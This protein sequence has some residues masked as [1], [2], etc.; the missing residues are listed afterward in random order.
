MNALTGLVAAVALA[1]AP[2]ARAAAQDSFPARPPAPGP[3]SPLTFPAFGDTTL[4]NGVNLVVIE[5]R[6]QPTVSM[7]LTFRGG[8]SFDPAG[9]EGLAELVA[10]LVTKGTPTRGAEQIAAT[11]EGAGGQLSASSDADFLTIS[12][13]VLSDKLDLAV[14]LLAD[15][16]RNATFPVDE[17]ELARTRYLSN[18]QAQLA[19]PD[20]IAARAFAKEIYGTHPYGRRPTE[21]S[22]KAITREDVRQFARTRLQPAGA[23]FVIAGDVSLAQV[24]ALFAKHFARWTGTAAVATPF[25]ALP[26]KRTPD[27]LLVHRPGSVQS[28]IIVGNPTMTPRDTNYYAARL[29]AHVLGGGTDSRLFLILREQKGWTYGA[30]AGLRRLRGMGYWEGTAEV[31]TAVTDSALKELLAQIHRIRTEVMPDSELTNAKGFLVGSFPRQIETPE[32]IASQVASVKR[33]GLPASYLETYRERLSAISPRRAQAAAANYFRRAGL[34]VVV[35]GDA[36]QVYDRLKAIAPVRLV[37]V[38]GAPLAIE[39]LSA[40]TGPVALDRTQLVTRSDSFRVVVQGNPMGIQVGTLH[41]DSGVQ[42]EATNIGGFLKQDTRVVFDTTD[43][44]VKEVHQTGSV[45]GQQLQTDLV[46][47][48]GRVKGTAM[49]PQPTGPKTITVDTTVVAGTID[50]NALS[51]LLPALPLE[52]GKTLALNVFVSSQ[53]AVIPAS[54]KVSGPESVT[55]PAGTFDALRV[56]VTGLPQGIAMWVSIAAPRRVVKIAPVGTPVVIELVK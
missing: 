53:A 40:P 1:A 8:A 15:V 12:S 51:V 37:A 35:V 3:L 56:D 20:V 55:V 5:N 50:E 52:A 16:T 17:L 10:E 38:E 22:Y 6:E 18:L 31:R 33:L 14:Q 26:V 49:T 19:Q 4:A 21:A 44:S 41:A 29:A 39:D 25:P 54:L 27:I 28:N 48:G 47:A 42:V 13:N 43:W 45:Q 34:T 30:F 24:R 2:A 11:I 32:Q 7:S 46:Y 36:Q 9:K 23:L